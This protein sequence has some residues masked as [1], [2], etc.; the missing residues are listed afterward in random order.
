[1][2]GHLLSS[3]SLESTQKL[4]ASPDS[5]YYIPNYQR[6]FA[7]DK[8]DIERFIEGIV[9]GIDSMASPDSSS[10]GSRAE[11]FM[12]TIVCFE[13]K[14]PFN[15]VSPKER[16]D[17]PKIVS[18]L[19]D[20]QQ[21]LTVCLATAVVLHDI[22]RRS[23]LDILENAVEAKVQDQFIGLK[24]KIKDSL[25]KMLAR[26]EVTGDR[27]YFPRIIREEIDCW[28]TNRS[29][30]KYK[31]PISYMLSEY[32]DYVKSNDNDD[33]FRFKLSCKQGE[34][35]GKIFESIK[36]NIKW[37]SEHDSS[38]EKSADR[39]FGLLPDI[40]V[41]FCT[42]A[43]YTKLL[44]LDSKIDPFSSI[45]KEIYKEGNK[46]D[47]KK[48]ESLTGLLKKYLEVSRILVFAKEILI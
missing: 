22:L 39:S 26:E 18:I 2:E 31:S 36:C 25:Y 47:R 29:K 14:A 33:E 24:D 11:T 27:K 42:K 35:F 40:E 34:V 15:S 5:C 4:L 10:K 9:E 46:K 3:P 48:T 1:M 45:K 41:F 17:L 8:D 43:F 23:K 38:S 19:V 28:S 32:I 44:E 12:G 30:S 13:D 7:W 37:L 6:Y 16:N 20:G 21:R